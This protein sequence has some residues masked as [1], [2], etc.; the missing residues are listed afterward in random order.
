MSIVPVPLIVTHVDERG[1]GEQP[2]RVY[3]ALLF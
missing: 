2:V 3:A 1:D